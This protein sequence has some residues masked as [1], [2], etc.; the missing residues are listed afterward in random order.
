[1]KNSHNTY[2]TAKHIAAGAFL[3]FGRYVAAR[4]LSRRWGKKL[5]WPAPAQCKQLQCPSGNT[6]T[7]EFDGPAD[8]PPLIFIHGINANATQWYHQRQYFRERYRLIFLSL[9]LHIPRRAPY[10]LAIPTL[11]A[12]LNSVFNQ[13]NL[14]QAV[15]YGHS[16]GGMV[17]L[18]YCT[19][20]FNPAHVQA[21]VLQGASYT[22]PIITN[23]YAFLL[24]PLQRPVLIPLFEWM[25]RHRQVLN[26]LSSINFLNGLSFLFYRYVHFAGAQTANQLL[27]VMAMAPTNDTG[28]VA[29]SLLQLM[30]YDVTP[31]LPQI[32]IPVLLFSGL[33]DRLNTVHSNLYLQQH[34]PQAQ[35]T[36][37]AAGHQGMVEK[38]HE[39]NAAIAQFL[40]KL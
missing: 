23:P 1:M 25:K 26:L 24:K 30:Q 20:H 10:R 4:L 17:L 2:R 33:H 18:K 8:A 39:V 35:L 9:P 13:L 7:A 16:M 21:I 6:W 5:H 32:N 11:A 3:L 27:Y 22:N 12:D 34:L 31:K 14:K 15:V 19:Q 38:H 40:N 37:I 28:A 29:E 36:F